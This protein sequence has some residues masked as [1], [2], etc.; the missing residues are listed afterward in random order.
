MARYRVILRACDRV[1]SAHG[2]PRPFGLD[3]TTLVKLSFLSLAH[4]L[5]PTDH[6]IEVVGDGLSDE[7]ARFFE[8][9]P[10]AV[11][12][13]D[14]GNARSLAQ[15]LELAYAAEDWV[16]L[17]ED[18][19]LYDPRAFAW[20]D[21]LLESRDRYLTYAP[22]PRWRSWRV[23]DLQRNPV[24]I[25]FPDYP[26]RYRAKYRRPSLLFHSANCHWRQT[27]HTTWSF[28]APAA[29]LRRRRALIDRHAAAVADRQLSEALFAD[30]WF[31][32]RVLC[33]SPLP[34][35]ATHMHE[36]TMSVLGDWERI[37]RETRQRLAEIEGRESSDRSG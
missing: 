6:A 8:S 31:R 25:F 17:C 29:E 37:Q 4:A 14:L 33:L 24:F 2:R 15:S 10:V 26:D 19:Y 13:G 5:E 1:A 36:G 35:L 34:G 30:L 27:T 28:L 3:K 11:H 20:A 12:H 18:D 7:L 22:R 32:G 21:E 23:G 16:Y 9:F